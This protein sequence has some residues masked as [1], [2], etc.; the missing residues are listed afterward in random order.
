MKRIISLVILLLLLTSCGGSETPAATNAPAPQQTEAAPEAPTPEAPTPETPAEADAPNADGYIFVYNGEN[1]YLAENMDTV[2]AKLGEPR[3][4]LEEPSCAFPGESDRVYGYAGAN[5]Y[6][7]PEDGVYYVHTVNYM[8]DSITTPE[9]IR[10]GDSLEDVVAAY[11]DGY[12]ED[13]G[14]YTYTKGDTFLRFLI[15]DDMVILIKYG[16]TEY[17]DVM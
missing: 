5:I 1:V 4:T 7:Y 16:L 13:N 10:L 12:T 11:G 8:D 9:G 3:T 14:Q 2:L 17:M 6:T 15:Q